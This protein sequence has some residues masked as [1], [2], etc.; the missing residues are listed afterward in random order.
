MNVVTW[1]VNSLKVRLPHLEA[2]IGEIRPNVICLQ[3]TKSED[4]NFPS[5]E[6][7]S[8]GYHVYF[9][10]QKTYNGVAILSDKPM[11]QVAIGIPGFADDQARVIAATTEDGKRFVNV[12]IPNGSSVDSPKF[13]YKLRWL[14]AA[15]KYIQAE[16]VNY[17]SLIMLGDFNIAPTDKDVY[18]PKEFEETVLCSSKERAHF[19]NLLRLGLYDSLDKFVEGRNRFTWWDYR[20]NAFR[21][22]LGLRIDHILLTENLMNSCSSAAVLNS[23]RK[24]ERPSDHAPVVV[25]LEI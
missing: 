25:N 17:E 15:T 3:E 19:E 12:Y 2:L 9:Y 18:D 8:L 16:L 14:D 7:E 10:G 11:T 24:L 5:V 22:K 13:E 21:R 20:M 4:R 1:N 6:I 23:Y